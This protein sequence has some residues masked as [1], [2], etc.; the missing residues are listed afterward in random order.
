MFD[1]PDFRERG[2]VN[3][4][5]SAFQPRDP[6]A[7]PPMHIEAEMSCLG[8]MLHDN[9]KIDAVL[10]I[11]RA[12]DFFRDKHSIIFRRVEALHKRGSP[13]DAVTLVDDLRTIGLFETIGGLD[14]LA[15]VCNC[16]PHAANAEYY[17]EIV[18]G[19]AKARLAIEQA[20]EVIRRAYSQQETPEDV[21]DA[22]A[23]MIEGIRSENEDDEL[24]INPLP[25]RM[26]DAAFP[27][28][29]GDIIGR[30]EPETEACREGILGQ[31]LVAFGN[32]M[33]RRPHWEVS[34][35]PHR[36][37]LYLC[38]TGPTGSGRK[39]TS[40]DGSHW[41]LSFCDE[42]WARTPPLS[43]SV[44]GEGVIE[45]ANDSD[46][47]MLFVEEEFGRVLVGA[48]RD[49]N[50]LSHVLRLGFDGRPLSLLTRKD[51]LYAAQSYI[52]FIGHITYSELK[53]LITQNDIENGLVNRFLWMHTFRSR[54]LPEG[55]DF[56]SVRQALGPFVEQLIWAVD[57][58]RH[59]RGLDVPYMRTKE[60]KELWKPLYEDL[61][62]PLPGYYGNAVERRA[63]I[64]TR[65]AMIYAV[66]DRSHYIDVKHI[67]AALAVWRYCDSTAAHIFGAPKK[68]ARL[69]KLTEILDS[70]GN[71]LTRTEINRKLGNGR[72]TSAELDS[73]IDAAYASGK[74]LYKEVKTAG[75][76]RRLL[77]NKRYSKEGI[78]I[79]K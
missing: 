58:A 64:V 36:G 29:I 35:R 18:K 10:A 71:G 17:A 6:E 14:Y 72:I 26:D 69:A 55:G 4:L 68:D 77:V 20:Q 47:P 63:P 19:K 8:A 49:G 44:S 25:A 54:S 79:E 70:A 33:G 53:K 46:D 43:G 32:L 12:E 59:D 52:S 3:R 73:L 13:V 39:G 78:P 41:L 56:F 74:Y 61:T 1:E 67:E 42:K 24:A 57:F 22:A 66:L 30:I 2:S 28:F 48:G 11:V 65:I 50:T 62:R 15:D 21:L 23:Q 51:S 9:G 38:L 37:N 76:K 60:A 45:K 27:G 7:L 40:W 16:V 31:F 5:T 34:G 75:H